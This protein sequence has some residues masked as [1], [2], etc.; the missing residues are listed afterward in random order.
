MPS[1]DR[2][3][4]MD[5]REVQVLRT[6]T[7]AHA[8]TDLQ[9][10]RMKGVQAWCVVDVALQTGL[11]ASELARIKVGNFDPKRRSLRVWRHKRR[12]RKQE[13]I[14]IGAD[15]AGHLAEFLEW[16]R[17]IGQDT[18][19]ED[20]LFVGKRGP[21][22]T[23]G[24]QQIWKAAVKRAGLPA[25]LSIHC[26]RHTMAVHLLKKTGNLRMVQKQLGHFSPTITA[27]M[28]ADITFDDM[29]AGLD[30]LYGDG[31]Q[32]RSPASV[33]AAS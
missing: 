20:A 14:A 11:R 27:N 19:R 12:E 7:E 4:Y 29:Q 21:L 31:G 6:V 5:N 13:T 16:K 32:S 26:A 18:S 8:I 17:M 23:R 24:L 1:I 15:L 25:E 22:T 9:H 30:G 10:G 33:S 3:K 2:E 28:Y